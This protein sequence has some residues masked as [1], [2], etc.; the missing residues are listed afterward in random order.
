MKE[1]TA[2]QV[3]TEFETFRNS[4]IHTAVVSISIFVY[5]GVSDDFLSIDEKKNFLNADR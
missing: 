2:K 1:F 3:S 5:S 4:M